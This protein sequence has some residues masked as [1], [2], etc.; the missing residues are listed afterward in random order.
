MSSRVSKSFT[1][2]FYVCGFLACLVLM[3]GKINSYASIQGASYYKLN[4]I[5]VYNVGNDLLSTHANQYRNMRVRDIKGNG[6]GERQ[7]FRWLYKSFEV[8]LYSA[9][10]NLFSIKNIGKYLVLL[11]YT[12]VMFLSFI[13]T[14]KI[15]N[16]VQELQCP[17]VK[18]KQIKQ[19]KQIKIINALAFFSIY[20]FILLLTSLSEWFTFIELFALLLAIYSTVNKNIYFFIIA[21]VIGVANRESGIALG[22]IYP[23]LHYKH[24]SIRSILS[25]ILFPLVFFITINIDIIKDF[26]Q[27]IMYTTAKDEFRVSLFKLSSF[28]YVSIGELVNYFFTYAVFLYPLIYMLIKL[29]KSDIANWICSISFMYVLII[30]IGSYIGNFKLLLL[31]LPSYMLVLSIY[32]ARKN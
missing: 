30:L 1:L 6:L 10:N 23:L 19:I 7:K 26:P 4:P 2:V 24:M 16:A 25:I 22:V 8:N 11:H 31:L 20:Q 17:A 3:N 18:I 27:L 15:F 28:S 21:I 13:L 12:T 9:L 32:Q 29:P 14:I 5:G